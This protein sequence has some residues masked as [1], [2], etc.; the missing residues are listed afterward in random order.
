[1]ITACSA[2]IKAITEN[3][4]V[5]TTA[6]VAALSEADDVA[7]LTLDAYPAPAGTRQYMMTSVGVAWNVLEQA[8]NARIELIEVTFR[9]TEGG[10]RGAAQAHFNCPVRYNAEKNA[11]YFARSALDRPIER[12]DAAYHAI[13]RRYLSTS[14]DEIAGRSRDAVSGEIA[15][16]MEFGACT[17]ETVAQRLRLEPRSL[18]RR[19]QKEGVAFRDLIDGWRK[20]R[21]LSLI[22]H[23]LLPLSEVSLALG[24]TDQSIFSRAFQRWYG[25]APLA[26]RNRDAARDAPR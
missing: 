3:L 14:K 21:A 11:L 8:G 7:V 18:Q 15:R 9:S 13:I 25:K 16:Q 5:H 17:L 19:L 6:T 4:I 26:F 1:M 12:T 22:C 24:Y 10:I 23:T 2:A 20:A